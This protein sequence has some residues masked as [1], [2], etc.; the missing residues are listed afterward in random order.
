MECALCWCKYEVHSGVRVSQGEEHPC[1]SQS[2]ALKIL[3]RPFDNGLFPPWH[4]ERKR[5]KHYSGR[6]EKTC[7]WY[8]SQLAYRL[9][10][11]HQ[12]LFE[13]NFAIISFQFFLFV[14]LQTGVGG[15]GYPRMTVGGSE[16]WSPGQGM[17]TH[18]KAQSTHPCLTDRLL[19]VCGAAKRW[20]F[21]SCIRRRGSHW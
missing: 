2:T 6:G 3:K 21:D 5:E 19:R 9:S 1:L 11:L 13:K 8:L 4:W 15:L 18:Q 14:C 7:H 16:W 10:F 17:L 20:R 12:M